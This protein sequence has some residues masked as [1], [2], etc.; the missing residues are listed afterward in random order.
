MDEYI[1]HPRTGGPTKLVAK[2]ATGKIKQTA[3]FQYDGSGRLTSENYN[4]PDGKST[5]STMYRYDAGV[6]IEELLRDG[7]GALRSRRVFEYKAGAMTTMTLYDGT[8]KLESKL[9]FTTK[10]G[11]VI[12]GK[13]TASPDAERFQ[14]AYENKH[15]VSLVFYDPQ[16]SMLAQISY[17]YDGSG[18]ITERLRT[19]GPVR[20]LCKYAYDKQGRMISYSYFDA[21]TNTWALEKTLLLEY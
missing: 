4:G 7:T 21:A 9:E 1:L 12:A 6:I 5:G 3:S 17:T 14:I 13:E 15:P 2:D 20:S 11:L 16:G 19:A 18:K 8:G 10:D